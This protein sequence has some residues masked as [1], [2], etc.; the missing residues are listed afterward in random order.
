MSFPFYKQQD[1]MDCGPTCLRMIAKQYGKT[2]DIN[3]LRNQGQYSKDGVS[4]LGISKAAEKIGFKTLA[5]K[6]DTQ[7]VINET[8]LPCILHWNQNHFVVL[9]KATKNNFTIAD[10]AK[11]IIK[12]SKQEFQKSWISDK[13]AEKGIALLLEPTAAKKQR[14]RLGLTFKIYF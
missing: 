4:L 1:V 5:V 12:L 13:E 6:F 8:P 3:N 7:T 2:L 14:H 11:G 9:Y 10:P